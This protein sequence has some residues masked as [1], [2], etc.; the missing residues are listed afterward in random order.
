MMAPSLSRRRLVVAM[1]GGALTLGVRLPAMTA[2]QAENESDPAAARMAAGVPAADPGIGFAPNAWLTLFPDGTVE[3]NLHKA[4]MGQGV[5]TALPM[6]VAE[7]LDADWSTVRVR[8]AAGDPAYG[9]FGQQ[10][11]FGSTSVASS[12]LPLRQAGATARAL[13]VAAAAERWSVSPESCRTEAGTVV[14]DASGRVLPYGELLAEAARIEAPAEVPLKAPSAFRLLGTSVPRVDLREKVTGEARYGIDADAP[15]MLTATVLRPPVFGGRVLAFD[16]APALAV[17]GVRHVIEVPSA[18]PGIDGGISI[19]GDGFWAAASGRRALI[20]AEAVEWDLGP[21]AQRDEALIRYRFAETAQQPGPLAFA[22][23]NAADAFAEAPR[24]L[25]VLYTTP[26]LAHA[27]MEPMTAAAW[28]RDGE[29]E[30]WTGTQG[31]SFVF[32]LAEALTGLPADQVTLHQLLLGCGLGRRAESDVVADAIQ[33]SQRVG[34][35]VK[36]IWTRDEDLRHDFYRPLTVHR[37]RAGLD[38]DGS[39]LAWLHHVVGDSAAIT[40]FPFF[41]GRGP[42]GD[43]IDVMLVAGLTESFRYAVP[44]RRI[45][46]TIGRSGVPVGFWRGVGESH[47]TFVVE[48]VVDELAA[49]A[50]VDPL[51]YRRDH[52]TGDGRAAA[53]LDLVAEKS[54]W[55][56]A[57]APGRGRGVALTD[58]GGTIIAAVAEV[59]LSAEA[60][61]KAPFQVVRL[62]LAVDCGFRVNPDIARQMVE[63]GALFGLSAALGEQA[64]LAAGGMVQA[65]LDDYRLLRF[66]QA[67]P[68]DVWFI[69]SDAPPTGLGEPAVVVVPPAVANALF[70]ATGERRRELP[71]G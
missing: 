20:E 33:V 15:G 30:I 11:T 66:D 52:L 41:L 43:E 21:M 58:Y 9:S 36:V 32:S 17:A 59:E 24:Q 69:Q 2:A 45:E 44:N 42:E 57:P 71:L 48:G 64:T 49:V 23:G 19:V 62:T 25:D 39:P 37:V 46:S 56:T 27:T 50:G 63:G 5:A 1:A 65:N 61:E 18:G 47:N 31:P 38:A 35:P 13:L 60:G 67:P 8:P 4:E 6:L 12:W 10:F 16:P 70:A 28:V 3:I 26:F 54:G 40:R 34:A 7:E 22:E 29:V 68:V 55:S 14:H 51:Q 53:V